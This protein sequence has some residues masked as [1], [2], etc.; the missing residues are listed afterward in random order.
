MIKFLFSLIVCFSF[1]LNSFGQNNKVYGK[2]KYEWKKTKP[3]VGVIMSELIFDKNK[4]LFEW[5]NKKSTTNQ[6]NDNTT[7]YFLN[8]KNNL[9][10]WI[11]KN[12]VERVIYLNLFVND[13]NYLVRNDRLNLDWDLEDEYRNIHNFQ[14]Q[15]ATTTYEGIKITAWFAE[16]LAISYGPHIWTGLPGLILEVYDEKFVN[17]FI[18]TNL[19]INQNPSKEFDKLNT[20]EITKFITVSD[21]DQIIDSSIKDLENKLN[22]RRETNEKPIRFNDDCEDCN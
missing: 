12:S 6:E 1:S 16:E 5:Q 13:I 19:E 9:D 14:C 3:Q 18:A 8:S 7:N 22:S 21:Y 20:L 15:K 17:H 10:N 2:V 4:S 11:L